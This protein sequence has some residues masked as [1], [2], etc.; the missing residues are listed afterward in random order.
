MTSSGLYTCK[1]RDR[2]YRILS[3]RDQISELECRA[4]EAKAK[5]A[6]EVF[7]V[8]GEKAGEE[9]EIRKAVRIAKRDIGAVMDDL[10]WWKLLWRVDDVRV[11]VDSAVNGAWCK[12]LELTLAFNAGRLASL[13]Q[14]SEKSS[15]SLLVSLPT[16][17]P[18]H[19]SLLENRL[20]QISSTLSYPLDADAFSSPLHSRREQLKWPT[21]RLHATAQQAVITMAG[22]SFGGLGIAWAGWAGQLGLYDIGMQVETALGVGLLSTVVGVRWAVGRFER[23][24]KRWW[25]DWNRVGEGLERDL[26]VT[27]DKTMDERVLVVSKTAAA[28][29]RQLAA[30][31]KDEIEEL[32]YE[33]SVLEDELRKSV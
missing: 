33:V 22:S 10:T 7:G 24:K 6:R 28:G 1:P 31:R 21:A 16:T 29:L 5:A 23:A 2:S 4:E 17:S 32:R 8:A 30:K 9:D 3:I 26:R 18:F 14:S 13:Q 15:K 11:I 25:Q 19:S 20:Q 27:L 12:D